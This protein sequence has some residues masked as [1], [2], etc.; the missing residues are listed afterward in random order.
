MDRLHLRRQFVKATRGI[1]FGR[2]NTVITKANTFHLIS[3]PP[4]SPHGTINAWELLK[5][6]KQKGTI[7]EAIEYP[8][9]VIK[10]AHKL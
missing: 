8:C 1:R 5:K 10:K 3:P 6:L 2:F 9:I 4:A 7:Q